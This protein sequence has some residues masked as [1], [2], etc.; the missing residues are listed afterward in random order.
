MTDAE[1]IPRLPAALLDAVVAYFKPR[2]V[3]LFGSHARGTARP[4]SDYDLLVVTE[5]DA[6]AERLT[7]RAGYEARRGFR[8][9]A[10][11]VPC[12]ESTFRRRAR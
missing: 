10:D 1:A 8:G 2:R 9:A 4:D 3:I 5:D 11:V 7:L 6:P 12:R